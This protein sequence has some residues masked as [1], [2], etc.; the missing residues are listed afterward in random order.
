MF[1][2]YHVQIIEGDVCRRMKTLLPL[3]GHIQIASVPAR[4]EPDNGELDYR[5]VLNAIREL[6]FTAPLG[7]E[8][9]PASTTEAGLGWMQTLRG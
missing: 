3:I 9:K 6:G 2:C 8:Y 5:Y 1:D 7:A 4:T